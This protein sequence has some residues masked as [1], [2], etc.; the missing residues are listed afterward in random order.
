MNAVKR[1]EPAKQVAMCCCRWQNFWRRLIAVKEKSAPSPNNSL[2]RL[3]AQEF[4][5]AFRFT[6]ATVPTL[7]KSVF[8]RQTNPPFTSALVVLHLLSV[9]GRWPNNSERRHLPLFQRAGR[10]NGEPGAN[11]CGRQH[12]VEV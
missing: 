2:L 7:I 3:K 1:D 8:H 4:S 5:H 11:V 6:N 9:A 12:L 10:E